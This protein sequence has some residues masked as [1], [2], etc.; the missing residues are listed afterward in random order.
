M[1]KDNLILFPKKSNSIV[2]MTE[3]EVKWMISGSLMLILALSLGLNS[4]IFNQTEA[5]QGVQNSR[6]IASIDPVFK[7]S[8]EKKALEVLEN[9]D[10]REIAS[11]G[12]EPSAIDQLAFGALAGKYAI[13]MEAGRLSEIHIS[14]SD[15]PK[16]LGDREKFIL[17]HLSLFGYNTAHV[18]R[19]YKNAQLDG[20]IE[21]YSI[22]SHQ[23]QSQ[24]EFRLD[25]EG[26]LISMKVQ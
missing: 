18:E 7:V 5:E 26:R 12:K 15:Q 3:N 19:S 16:Y 21:E 4:A 6:A 22:T 24:V 1:S 10:E 25:K 13:R 23:D 20:Q 17:K 11:M 9:T 2:S 14:S 8:W